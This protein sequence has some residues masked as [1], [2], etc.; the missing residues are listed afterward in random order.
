MNLVN[1]TLQYFKVSDGT[2]LYYQKWMP[3]HPKAIIIFVHGLADHVGRYNC[4]INYFARRGFG[5]CMFDLRG[6]GRS[7]G[8]RTHIDH[9]SDYLY[10][11]SQF[12]EFIKKGSP[13]APIFLMGHSFGGQLVLNF[14]VKYSK[15]LRGI[16]VL[17]PC[18]DI[19][20]NIPKWKVRLGEWGSRWFPTFRVK[21]NIDPRLLSH[22]EGIVNE[23]VND[24]NVRKD[25]TLRCG[26]EIMKNAELVMAI[27]SRIHL[28]VMMM[29]GSEDGICGV[30]ATKKFF[31]R[32]PVANK[33]LKIYHGYYHE[34][35]NESVRDDILKEIEL[36]I[37]GQLDAELKLAGV[38]GRRG[39]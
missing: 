10:D 31:A 13:H 21:N 26:Y 1:A 35:L 8:R 3:P 33:Q 24:K 36:W 9:F 14:V 22:D 19:K 6:H 20:V 5:I 7:D 27:A 17:S 32:I 34:L 15:A 38:A 30:D 39:A 25:I 18:I 16:V 11:I 2:R 37:E 4:L 29:H 28:P 23:Y 12:I